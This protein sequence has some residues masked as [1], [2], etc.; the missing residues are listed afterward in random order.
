MTPLS[1]RVLALSAMAVA[2]ALLT[3]G[4]AVAATPCPGPEALTERFLQADGSGAAAIIEA[5]DYRQDALTLG[6][7]IN[8]AGA[9]AVDAG[10]GHE[11]ADAVAYAFPH[12]R[13]PVATATEAFQVGGS[14]AIQRGLTPEQAAIGAETVAKTY[15]TYLTYFA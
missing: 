5:C 15:F 11:Y 10:R 6:A 1:R 8:D 13:V 9:P 7:A 14:V 2:G 3:P 4:P 12:A